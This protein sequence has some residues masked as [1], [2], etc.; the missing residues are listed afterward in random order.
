MKHT[1]FLTMLAA[2]LLGSGVANAAETLYASQYT[3]GS[4][5]LG[6]SKTYDELVVD[7]PLTLTT[8]NGYLVLSD[9]ATF[10]F[11]AGNS[12]AIC[13]ISTAANLPDNY[14]SILPQGSGG[15][16]Y[17]SFDD[18]AQALIA[19]SSG[20]P[21]TLIQDQNMQ[22]K[23][24]DVPDGTTLTLNGAGYNQ[25]VEMNGVS[26]TYVGP[27]SSDYTFKAGQIGFTGYYD[28]SHA[29]K[30]V[31]GGSPTP[32]PTTGTLGLLALAALSA[33]RRRI[34]K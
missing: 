21:I 15:A 14:N 27:Q 22:C 33:R 17:F 24:F 6:S 9:G 8:K 31:V 18:G 5:T 30:L 28:G 1:M 26:F 3:S 19:A 23:G 4:I 20:T 25:T 29:L 34:F 12:G 2:A 7:T 10:K 32:E 11:R 16:Y 13:S